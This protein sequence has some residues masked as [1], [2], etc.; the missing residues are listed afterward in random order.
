M[1]AGPTVEVYPAGGAHKDGDPLG[2][3]SPWFSGSSSKDGP[4]DVSLGLAVSSEYKAITGSPWPNIV[5]PYR[6]TTLTAISQLGD[7]ERDFYTWSFE[8]GTTL[9]GRHVE[10]MFTT[11][12]RQQVTLSQS[13]ASTGETYT[14]EATIMVKYV[15]REIRQ[16]TDRD[17]EAFLTAMEVIY[18][19][20]PNVGRS[21]YGDEFK[22]IHYFVQMHLEGAGITD[23]DHWHDDAGIMTHHVG[24]TLLFEQALQVIDP[25]VS[26]PYWEYTIESSLGLDS[27]GDSV[28]F[29]PNWLGAASPDNDFHTISEGRWAFLPIKTD[30][31]STVHNSYGLLRAP[32]NTD[33]TPY[34]TR[35]NTTNSKTST[36]MVTCSTYQACFDTSSLAD[37][38]NCLNG[39]T[40][41]PVHILTGGEWEDPEEDLI[42]NLGLNA[43]IPL[44]SKYL[45]RKGYMRMPEMCT[46]EENG[47]GSKSTCRASCP[48]EL[49]ESRGMTPYDVL[50]DTLALYWSAESAE[51]VIKYLSDEDRFVVAGHE[52]DEEFQQALWKKLLLALCDP[53][54]VGDMYT[55]S[56]PYD[57]VF[58][59]IHPSAERLLSWRRMMADD[60]I[61]GYQFDEKW[62]YSHGH[63][64]G[65]TGM[66]CNW[67]DVRADSLDMPTCE[68]GICGGH[69]PTDV[70]PFRIKVGGEYVT[71]TNREWLEFI[72]PNNEE[73]PYMYNE[74][75]WDHCAAEG[76]SMGTYT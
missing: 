55:S 59:V 4:G 58:W 21:R 25:S 35:H 22:S 42:T 31:W 18:R 5:E 34:L 41:G 30:T 47:M 23:C 17:R 2:K 50:E 38:N 62:G 49:Y 26:I 66:V 36:S 14:T 16:L 63:V 28:I 61:E 76:N 67:S 69:T 3:D 65:E 57:P 43:I 7:P 73:L 53:G 27:Y 45:W 19:L 56:A 1:G 75:R 8:D 74:Y 20:D 11:V 37:M 72:S 13:F 6:K 12:G 54:H 71:M 68:K 52:D 60:G 64:I 51:H 15:R 39:G 70:L 40:H 29:S 32:W 33:S 9:E 46:E 10:H 44:L 24:F 48:P